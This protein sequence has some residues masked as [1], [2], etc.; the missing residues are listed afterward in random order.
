MTDQNLSSSFTFLHKFISP[1]VSIIIFIIIIRFL[2]ADLI[3]RA[4]PAVALIIFLTF[5]ASFV[6]MFWLS[7]S[8]K[9]V[10]ISDGNLMICD[11]SKEIS[12]DI[13]DVSDVVEMRW[14]QPYWI[15]IH[16]NH[17]TEF[18]RSIIFVPP[19]RLLSFW[20]ANPLVDKLK[21]YVHSRKGYVNSNRYGS[22]Y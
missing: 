15:T 22:R 19:F 3:L 10:K 12:V 1:F 2:H 21:G 18:G 4:G 9:R 20:V 13:A 7:Y 5:A 11:Y 16:F 14:M 17:E 8:I 6:M